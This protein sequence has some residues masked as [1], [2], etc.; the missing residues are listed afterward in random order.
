MSFGLLR[1][2]RSQ[3]GAAVVEFALVLP[4]LLLFVF[5]IVEFGRAYNAQLTL[6]HAARE[7]VRVR[8]LGGTTAATTTATQNAAVPYTG[9]SVAVGACTPGSA[10]QVTATRPFQWIFMPPGL[11]FS[12]YTQVGTGV[13]RCTG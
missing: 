7:G 9:V 3:Q 12:N 13:M 5:G 8:A 2:L 6:T 1:R 11:S 10:T 4:I